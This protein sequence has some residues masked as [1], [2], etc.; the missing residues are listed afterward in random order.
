MTDEWQKNF[1]KAREYMKRA[2][3]TNPK[4]VA[5]YEKFTQEYY[6]DHPELQVKIQPL[7]VEPPP[8]KKD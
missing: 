2:T 1:K 4:T 6:C 7:V 5:E 3:S 8:A